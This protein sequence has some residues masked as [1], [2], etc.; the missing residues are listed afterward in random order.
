MSEHLGVS[1]PS[2]LAVE[3]VPG[4]LPVLGVTD[5]GLGNTTW[6]AS[7]DGEVIVIDPERDP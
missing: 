2:S 1:P 4:R 7:L 5:E 3:N 6:V